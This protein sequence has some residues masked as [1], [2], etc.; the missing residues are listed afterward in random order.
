MTGDIGTESD[1][2][3]VH[4]K[5]LAVRRELVKRAPGSAEAALDLARTL[6]DIGNLHTDPDDLA[7]AME[8]LKEAQEL[9]ENVEASGQGSDAGRYVLAR[10]VYGQ[11]VKL[12]RSSDP[13]KATELFDRATAILQALFD[14]NPDDEDFQWGLASALDGQAHLLS[15]PA[16]GAGAYTVGNW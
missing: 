5:A 12:M 13:A 9:A 3:A 4:H 10:A 16:Q 11:G 7:G 2:L 6:T 15:D 8:P 1:A 14:A